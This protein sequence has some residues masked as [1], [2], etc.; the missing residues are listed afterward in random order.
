MKTLIS[1]VDMQLDDL[2]SDILAIIFSYFSNPKEMRKLKLTCHKWNDITKNHFYHD[3]KYYYSNLSNFIKCIFPNE[4]ER[5]HTKRLTYNN[6]N[7]MY[8]NKILFTV[9]YDYPY[10]YS[11]P[12]LS[13]KPVPYKYFSLLRKQCSKYS[14]NNK[15][16]LIKLNIPDKYKHPIIPDWYRKNFFDEIKKVLTY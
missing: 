7:G 16:W 15:V 4:S 10:K 2:P 13:S 9:K 6:K 5:R 14:G 12:D 8:N 1:F 11:E 3:P